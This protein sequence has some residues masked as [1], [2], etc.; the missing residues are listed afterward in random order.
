MKKK[1]SLVN[2]FIFNAGYSLLNVIFPLITTPYLSR[3]LLADGV[4]AVAFAEN[5][6]SY[7]VIFASL[8]IPTYGIREIAK[9]QSNFEERRKV[10]SEIFFINLIATVISSITYYAMILRSSAFSNS[11]SL[12][13]ISGLLLLFNVFN[14]DWFYKGMEEYGYI[15][16]RSMIMKIVSLIAMFT[17]VKTKGDFVVYA[18]IH[19]MAISGN[20]I[21]NILHIKKFTKLTLKNINCKRHMKVIIILLSTNIA[22]ELYAKLDT[23]MIGFMCGKEYVGYYSNAIKLVK[24]IVTLIAALGTI[25]LPRLSSYINEGRSEDINELV[26]KATKFIITISIPA[27]IGLILLSQLVVNVVFGDSFAAAGRTMMI[28]SLLIPIM[29]IGNLYG[30]QLL[31]VFN[32]EK[33]LLYSVIIG[34]IVNVI[35]N[36]IMIPLYQQNGAAIASVISEAAVMIAQVI[37]AIKYVKINLT[38]SFL[39]NIFISNLVMALII[40]I[41]KVMK[42][43]QIVELC[44]AIT[45]GGATYIIFNILFKNDIVIFGVNKA[46][47]ILIK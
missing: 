8:G 24:I 44:I 31:M 1:K 41:V 2:N 11:L 27:A 3:V 20:Y 23:T 10:F 33:K 37:F 14:V 42:F 46:K 38:K 22:V 19:C 36:S 32:Q 16:I 6:V 39:R 43:Q 12:Y 7:F 4:G 9:V 25:L 21:F 34:A 15:T 47:K 45:I 18:F 26:T 29:T 13:C 30:T 5:I 17:F 35:L 28:L 40:N